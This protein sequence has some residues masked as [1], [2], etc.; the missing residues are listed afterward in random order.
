MSIK[1]KDVIAVQVKVDRLGMNLM[2]QAYFSG[3]LL[4]TFQPKSI[5]TVAICDQSDS[6]MERLAEEHRIEVIVIPER[7]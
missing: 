7:A 6:V 3:L 4:E 2:G 5:K 1:G